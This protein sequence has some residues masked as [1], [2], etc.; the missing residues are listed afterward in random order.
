[1][2][3]TSV[4]IKGKPVQFTPGPWEYDYGNTLGHVKSLGVRVN[5]PTTLRTPTVALY[6]VLPDDMMS[7]EEKRANA[8]LIAAAPEL[9]EALQLF[10]EFFDTMPKG[11]L[12]RITCDVGI[13]NNAFLKSRVALAKAV[14]A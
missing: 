4:P 3:Q 11:Q 14:E 12:G 10:V 5:D 13:L 7:A 6:D 9:Y 8:R 2:S 1:L